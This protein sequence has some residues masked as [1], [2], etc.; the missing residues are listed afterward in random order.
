MLQQK[1]S[2]EGLATEVLIDI[3]GDIS[4]LDSLDAIL[5]ASPVAWRVFDQHGVNILE[6]VLDSGYIHVHSCTIIRTIAAIRTNCFP[7]VSIPDLQRRVTYDS[8]LH[9]RTF[10]APVRDKFAPLELPKT[11]TIKVMRSI[12]N[13]ARRISFLTLGCLDSCLQRFSKSYPYDSSRVPHPAM[14]VYHPVWREEQIVYRGFWRIQLV[15][16]LKKALKDGTVTGW[17]DHEI[18]ALNNMSIEDIYQFADADREASRFESMAG[19]DSPLPMGCKTTEHNAVLSAEDYMK[20]K[21]ADA[22]SPPRSWFRAWPAPPITCE[23]IKD[24]E[25][26]HGDLY[27]AGT[28]GINIYEEAFR[29]CPE[30]I[31]PS[32]TPYRR[33]GFAI[34]T[35]E[36]LIGCRFSPPTQQW[37]NNRHFLKKILPYEEAA[38]I[39]QR[40]D[41]ECIWGLE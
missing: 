13:T 18:E 29:D 41:Q 5:R 21:A 17:E 36:R 24:L 25:R 28:L 20:E 39:L 32:F 27:A 12:I 38:K 9:G 7:V 33:L 40:E 22:L 11:S 8:L 14:V 2:F 15:Q 30:E 34:W 23:D 6:R 1:A 19:Y 10:K 35:S 26:C 37:Q 16:D 31:K 3:L 4:D